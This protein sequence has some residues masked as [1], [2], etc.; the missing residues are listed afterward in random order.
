MIPNDAAPKARAAARDNRGVASL[1]GPVTIAERARDG[2]VGPLA[3]IGHVAIVIRA[4]TR[5][6]SS[7]TDAQ[8]QYAFKDVTPGA[9]HT[10]GLRVAGCRSDRSCDHSD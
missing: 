9:L 5:A 2:Q 4:G 10:H 3:P 7:T 8:G 6:F 1:F